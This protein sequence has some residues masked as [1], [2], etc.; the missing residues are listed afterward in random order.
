[1]PLTADYITEDWHPKEDV[2]TLIYMNPRNWIYREKQKDRYPV[3]QLDLLK[4]DGKKVPVSKDPSFDN[5]WS[6]FSPTGDRIAHYRRRF[7][8]GR[9]KEYAVIC[10]PDGSRAKEVLAFTDTG[11]AEKL[12]WFRPVGFPCWSPD[13]KTIAWLVNTNTVARG[14]GEKVELMFIRADGGEQRRVSLTDKGFTWVSA[15]DWR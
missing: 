14:D 10:A 13:G 11:D 8:D 1:M 6:R 9:P 4:A 7:V 15:I 12:P 5:L 3:R 2:R